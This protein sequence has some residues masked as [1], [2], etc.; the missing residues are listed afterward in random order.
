MIGLSSSEG[1]FLI[2]VGASRRGGSLIGDHDGAC[3]GSSIS[4]TLRYFTL[5]T[6]SVF[7]GGSKEGREREIS[8][9]SLPGYYVLLTFPCA[10]VAAAMPTNDA[11]S[12]RKQTNKKGNK[13]NRE[14]GHGPLAHPSKIPISLHFSQSAPIPTATPPVPFTSLTSKSSYSLPNAKKCAKRLLKCGSL[15]KCSNAL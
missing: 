1:V 7:L 9:R 3:R 13:G 12:S 15:L 6:P 11:S 8:L 2:G 4:G 10:P 5:L 14:D